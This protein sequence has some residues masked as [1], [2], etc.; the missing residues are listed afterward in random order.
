MVELK[1]DEM[2]TDVAT[3]ANGGLSV[4]EDVQKDDKVPRGLFKRIC[5]QLRKLICI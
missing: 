5:V 2:A 3:F 1:I 4:S